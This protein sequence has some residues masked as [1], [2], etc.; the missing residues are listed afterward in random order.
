MMKYKVGFHLQQGYYVTVEAE[1]K[2]AA[3]EQISTLLD[4]GEPVPDAQQA[5]S[6]SS[7]VDSYEECPECLLE[8]GVTCECKDAPE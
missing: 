6:E 7:V 3:A 2:E 4:K 8:V 1:S 5:M